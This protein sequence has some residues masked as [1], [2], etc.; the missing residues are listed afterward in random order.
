MTTMSMERFINLSESILSLTDDEV[1]Y[2]EEVCQFY[3]DDTA[4]DLSYLD[5]ESAES[6]SSAVDFA[7]DVVNVIRVN[8]R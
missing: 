4:E 1:T 3:V 5:A 7:R 6:I 8:G 2:L